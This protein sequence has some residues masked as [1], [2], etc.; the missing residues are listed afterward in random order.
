MTYWKPGNV[1]ALRGI[2]GAALIAALGM[3]VANAQDADDDSA[4]VL[5]TIVVQ[6]QRLANQR[7]IDAKRS[8]DTI[9]DVLAADDLNELPDQN[10]AEGLSR[11]PGLT[12]FQDE[13]AGLYVGIRGLNQEFVNLTVDGMEV[14]SA[15]RTWDANARGA[16]LEAVPTT[17]VSQVEVIKATT[18][19]LD[20][21]AIA[22]T[23]NLVTRSA[24]NADKPWLSIGLAAGQYQEDVPSDDVGLS[25]KGNLS[26]GRVLGKQEK[27]GIVVDAN[28]RNV[29]RDNLKPYAFWG[30][31]ADPAA[32]P[33]E[34]GGYAYE[35]KEASYGLTGKLE[36]RP[37]DSLEGYVS[38]NFFDSE[39]DLDKNKHAL[40]APNSDTALETFDG[41]VATI[42][43][44]KVDY[45]VDGALTVAGGLDWAMDERNTVKL[46][47]STSTSS[48]YQDDPRVD[49]Y[50]GGPLSGNYE[51]TGESYVYLLDADSSDAF[52]DQGNY[53]FNGYRRYQEEL[54]KDVS[55]LKVD[56]TRAS[57]ENGGLG[58]KAGAKLK[59]TE[60]DFN[61]SYFRWRNPTVQA[62][63]AQFLYSENYN[64][65]GTTNSQFIMSDVGSLASFVEGLGPDSFG[66][67]QETGDGNDYTVSETVTSAYGL[68][69]Y[70]SDAIRLVVGLRYEATE[71]EAQNHFN[72]EDD[73]NWIG[74]NGDYGHVLPSAA[75]T[76]FAT[77]SLLVRLGASR[78][79]GRPD[80]KDLARGETPPND[81]GIYARGNKDLEPRTSDNFDASIEYYFDAGKSLI[82]VAAFQKNISDEI[83]DL[84]TPYVFTNDLN[85]QI[86]SYFV[87]PMNAGDATITGLEIGVV[88]DRLEFL[89]APFD[90]LGLSANFTLNEGEMDLVG[91]DGDTVRTVDPEGLSERLANLTVFYE[92]EK[93]SAR[94]AWK[95]ASDQTQQLSVDGS[96]DLRLEEYDQLDLSL[97]CKLSRRVEIFG[98]VWNALNDEQR[99]TNANDVVGVPNWYER[100]RYGQAFWLGVNVNY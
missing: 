67:V 38:A 1:R 86:E 34:L 62:D 59:K 93:L 100:V 63:F 5:D 2:S 66:K 20:G 42:R 89:P 76:W 92:G 13:G 87:Q 64:F 97:G 60:A 77:D 72:N 35:R 22:G 81:M 37:T 26:F 91:E 58:Y 78:T 85:E 7:A 98:E 68:A 94:A 83:F 61:S 25:S 99:F 47:A 27:I 71:T 18:P 28:F 69:N 8:S 65:P 16:N 29:E 40:Y 32:L 96:G 15:A 79:V 19:D 10:L 33:V 49:W 11:I 44:D 80:I 73:G 55:A 3:P 12:S 9:S 53:V 51:A 6:G 41:A 21:D 82:S 30:S 90:N 23:V 95:Y 84:Q 54:N 50:F 45:G 56:W 48:S 74:T 46:A 24:F 4:T 75:F 57:N 43:N 88:K 52:G 17:F 14:S 39:T 70:T 36:F 31:A